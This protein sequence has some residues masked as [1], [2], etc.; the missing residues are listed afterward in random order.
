MNILLN[1]PVTPE[2]LVFAFGVAV[3][4]VAQK[5]MRWE[6]AVIKGA[7]SFY[8]SKVDGIGAVAYLKSQCE[9][10]YIGDS[11]RIVLLPV[12]DTDKIRLRQ[13]QIVFGKRRKKGEH[14]I[15]PLFGTVPKPSLLPDV[16]YC[17][18][19]S[20]IADELKKMSFV[21]P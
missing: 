5:R 6:V 17:S 9:G 20:R 3:G 7:A 11:T 15:N 4:I 14:I 1:V 13:V 8:G 16:L 2:Q 18:D 12:P 10:R 21:A 19:F